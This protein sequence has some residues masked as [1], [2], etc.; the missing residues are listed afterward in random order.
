MSC[1]AEPVSLV[2]EIDPTANCVSS[3][4]QPRSIAGLPQSR[5][6]SSTIQP[7]AMVTIGASM[8]GE[9]LLKVF[10]VTFVIGLLVTGSAAFVAKRAHS[11]AACAPLQAA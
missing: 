10:A 7:R 1:Y 2:G 3:G 5:R 6:R 8:E 11:I 9:M 4:P